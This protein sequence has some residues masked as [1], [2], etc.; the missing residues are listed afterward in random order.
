MNKVILIILDG[1]GIGKNEK[2]NAIYN[3]KTQFIDHLKKNKINSKLFTHGIHVGLPKR[4]FGNSEVGHLNIGAGRVVDQ[5]LLRI[6]NSIKEKTIFNN[7]ILTKY[8]KYLVNFNKTL[9]II[10]LISNGGVHSNFNHLLFLCNYAK[11]SGVKRIYIHGFTDGRDSNPKNGIKFIRKL[12]NNNSPEI[13]LVSVIGRYYAMD[14]DKRWERT[15]LAYDLL[16]KG[17]GERSKI[18]SNS[19]LE[20]YKKG[21]TD[22]FIKPI[23]KVDNNRKKNYNIKSGDVVI[24]F[25]FR[26]DRSRQ[27][28]EAISQNKILSHNMSPINVIMITMTNYND[29]YKNINVLFKKEKLKNTLGEVLSKNNNKQIRIAETEKYP[30]VSYFFSGGREKKFKNEKRILIPSPKVKTYDLKPQ[31]SAKLITKRTIKEIKQNCYDFICLNFANPDMVGHTGKYNAVK[32]AIE[33]TDQSCKDV[34]K[35]AIK[36]NYSVMIIADH[37]NAEY[38]INKDGSENTS[39]TCNQVPCILINTKYKKIKNGSLK[40]VAPTILK[41]MNIKKPYEM[42]GNS[43]I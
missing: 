2:S 41:L 3:S 4:Q 33:I 40:D 18:I 27:I 7:N 6:N 29:S 35:E 26:N 43:L 15:K 36:Y 9:H 23:I 21:I 1:W 17:E 42:T 14:R 39:H 13:K 10:G 31:M 24:N 25:N 37:G 22:E 38:M 20:S 19:I 12:E 8:F 34:V 32:K 28:T 16:V 11:Q 5:D 30:H